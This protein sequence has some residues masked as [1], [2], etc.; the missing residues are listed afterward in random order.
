[1]IEI[2]S[3]R[4]PMNHQAALTR[5]NQSTRAIRVLLVDDNPAQL[6]LAEYLLRSYQLEVTCCTSGM[7][8]LRELAIYSYDLVCLDQNMPGL[9]GEE[10]ARIIRLTPSAY[11][12]VPL[13]AVSAQPVNLHTG[14]SPSEC[15]SDQISKPLNEEKLLKLLHQ[16][17]HFEGVAS[18]LT[19]S[20]AANDESD[21]IVDKTLGLELAA[22]NKKLAADLFNLLLT[23]LDQE[24][25]Q[26][27]RAYNLQ[28]ESVLLGHVHRL[29]GA[30][31]YCGVPEL[32]EAVRESE[33]II[34]SGNKNS[35]PAAINQLFAAI[36]NLLHW[37]AQHRW[38][39]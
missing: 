7:E 2:T 14:K 28:E 29:H 20:R 26:I 15:W 12:D 18:I 38:T 8:A 35:L 33:N 24:K 31:R 3:T 21:R 32:R 25:Q 11:Q 1:M 5:Q 9:S 30:T 13:I 27:A 36:D 4:L 10:L 6:Q 16:W 22:G 19:P 23:S 39:A 17:T 37:S 34:R